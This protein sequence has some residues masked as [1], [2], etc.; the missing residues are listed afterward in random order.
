MEIVLIMKD[1]QD[2][3]WRKCHKNERGSL[4]A[5]MHEIFYFP[6]HFA[7]YQVTCNWT[8]APLRRDREATRQDE[9]N[10][11]CMYYNI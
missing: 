7:L 6:Q 10:S 8:C 4:P 1:K 11:Q 3:M 5:K 9:N 2:N